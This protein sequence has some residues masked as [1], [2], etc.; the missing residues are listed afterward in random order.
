[1]LQTT[2]VD[3][4]SDVQRQWLEQL[5]VAADRSV[6][7]SLPEWI[8][9]AFKARSWLEGEPLACKLNSEGVYAALRLLVP[10]EKEKKRNAR[11]KH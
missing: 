3:D 5:K 4:I 8:F 6:H 11:R 10:V 2:F 1:M 9:R 7:I